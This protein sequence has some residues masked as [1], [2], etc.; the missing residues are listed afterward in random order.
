MVNNFSINVG[1]DFETG[2]SASH[3][4]N[5]KSDGHRVNL[6]EL[7]KELFKLYLKEA[8]LKP[9]ESF[10]ELKNCADRIVK[11]LDNEDVLTS[12]SITADVG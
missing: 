10:L 9:R 1:T 8:K 3:R 7:A 2:W 4:L 11:S 12:S 5:V 6:C